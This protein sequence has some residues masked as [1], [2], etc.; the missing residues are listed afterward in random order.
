HELKKLFKTKLRRV[1]GVRP[2]VR[3]GTSH[4]A[5]SQT[6]HRTVLMIPPFPVIKAT[7][8]EVLTDCRLVDGKFLLLTATCSLRLT[9]IQS[10]NFAYLEILT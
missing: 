6:K 3:R 10:R 1:T 7:F 4:R 9:E 2:G 5:R 8:V